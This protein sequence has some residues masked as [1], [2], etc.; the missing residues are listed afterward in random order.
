MKKFTLIELLVVITIIAILASLLLPS[1]SNARDRAKAIYCVNNLKQFGIAEL[2]YMNA[3]NDYIPPAYPA[4]SENDT[5][6]GIMVIWITLLHPY[7][8]GKNW[9]GGGPNTAQTLFCPSSEV[10]IYKYKTANGA[11]SRISN[12]IYNYRLGSPYYAYLD[13]YNYGWKKINRCRVPSLV[14]A[15]VDGKGKTRDLVMSYEVYQSGCYSVM[16]PRHHKNSSILFLDGHVDN[17]VI[18][19]INPV[20]Y[21][22]GF[23]LSNQVFQ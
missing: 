20:D 22:T 3:Y 11:G 18:A 15:M 2:S 10:Q 7:L 17:T 5:T 12:Y 9:D 1:L 6:S 4:Y 14:S 13:S 19:H 23:L 16:D 21:N 8:N